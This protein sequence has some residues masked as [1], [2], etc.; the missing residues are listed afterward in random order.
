LARNYLGGK[1]RGVLTIHGF[2]E[3]AELLSQLEKRGV[4]EVT[5]KLFDE[6]CSIVKNAMDTYAAAAIP[7]DLAAKQTEYKVVRGNVYQYAYGFDRNK[8]PDDFL[9]ACYLN[10]GTPERSTKDGKQRVMINGKWVTLGT[11]RGKIA[12]RGF[13]SNAKRSAAQ[14][15][16]ARKRAMLKEL[17]QRGNSK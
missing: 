10:Y 15:M 9:K 12:P 17:A 5:Q 2:A 13:I 1:N 16:N 7:A 6:S 11:G 14:K 4:D 3:M 8:N